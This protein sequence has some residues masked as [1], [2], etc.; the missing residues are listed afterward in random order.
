MAGVAAEALAF[1]DVRGQEADL[2]DLQSILNKC[3]PKLGDQAQQQL[4]RW[5]VWQ[6]ASM[7]KRHEKAFESSWRP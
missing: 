7:L 2:R 5:A 1:E 6:A 3:E 4:T